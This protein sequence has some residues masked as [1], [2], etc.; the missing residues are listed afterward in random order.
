MESD[1]E[2]IIQALVV[3]D[4]FNNNFSPICHNKPIGLLPIA[5]V[6]LIEYVLDSLNT[7][8]V[9]EVYL[10]CCYDGPKIKEYIK[11][12][13]QEKATWSLMLDVQIITSDTCQTMG[14]VMR[15][16]DAAA[17][18]RGYFI[19][20]GVNTITNVNFAS[21]LEQ[22]KLLCKKDKGAAM[23]LVY[24]EVS[25]KHPL[26]KN[27]TSILLA[28]NSTTKKILLHKKYKSNSN[29]ATFTL[30]L[31]CV[32]QHSEVKLHH[33][34]IDGN[35]ALCSP[36]VPPLFS[37]NFDFQTRH[38]FIHGI[39]INEDI[40]ASSLYYTLIK[41]NQYAAAVTNWKTYQTI[42]WDILHN[43][44][45][46]LSIE[47]GMLQRNTFL[48]SENSVARKFDCKLSRSSVMENNVII[49]TNTVI[50]D[51]TIIEQSVIGNNC[52][53]GSNCTIKGCHIM[54]NVIIKDNCTI[55]NCFIDNNSIVEENCNLEGVLAAS[56]SRVTSQSTL[57][58]AVLDE[59]DKATNDK[60]LLKSASDGTDWE[61]ESSGDDDEFIG[62][63]K[64][65]SD[66]ESCYSS[67][68]SVDSS[69]PG[70]P[71]PDDT[72]IF[73]QEVID[74]LARG[75]EEKL[76]CDYLI[77]EINSSRYAYN[78]QLHEVN[79]FVI[80]AM[81]SMPMLINSKS[82]LSTVKDILKYFRPVLA[83]YIKTK[84]SIMDCLKA[85]EES[86]LKNEWLNGKS[87]QVIHLFYEMD[88]VDEDSLLE[89]QNDMQEDE[90][91]LCKEASL[92]KF[93][94]WLQQA[95]EESEESD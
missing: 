24:K 11:K 74:S 34:L 73:L 61:N 68:S 21:L 65:W 27:D 91:P 4:L 10:F 2:N 18:L 85:I 44:V 78:I 58:G 20:L 93:F 62:F 16:V 67:D 59:A 48:L 80:R 49:G 40:L 17:I 5:G 45:H 60:T 83:N 36:S 76:K 51:S 1:K 95:S 31:D 79:F 53:I 69:M 55:K 70:S 82:V 15:E 72:N 23:T 56:D 33:N 7:G 26:I 94:E 84:P 47:T 3:M 25:W 89:W 19:L 35:I 71:I 8:G 92:V 22:H 90:S 38:D 77:L 64:V 32:L 9:A 57:K 6:P 28:A 39:L 13:K 50:G 63:E 30:P 41:G 88:V 12:R 14:D 42:C 46:P 37:D 52:V 81:L 66:S 43:W 75:Y 29:D 86:C 54:N 87:G